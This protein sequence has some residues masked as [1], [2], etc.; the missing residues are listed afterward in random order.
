MHLSSRGFTLLELLAAMG[1]LV[2]IVLMMARIFADTTRMWNLGTKRI[3]ETQEARVVIDFLAR[4]I[5]MAIADELVSFKIH[6]ETSTSNMSVRAYGDD[7]DSICFVTTPR[8]PPSISRRSGNQHIYY[9]DYMRDP[10]NAT[11]VINEGHPEG[12]RYQLLRRTLTEAM[13]SFAGRTVSNDDPELDL[14]SSLRNL[15]VMNTAYR[16]KDWWLPALMSFSP[17]QVVLDNVVAFEIWA[18][19]EHYPSDMGY[20]FDST[21]VPNPPVRDEDGNP[22]PLGAPLWIDLYLEVIGEQESAKLGELWRQN[23]PDFAAF[24]EENV[25]RYSTRIYFRNREKMAE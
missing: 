10:T 17:G 24:R 2:I 15:G 16:R 22:R 9:V 18:E 1:I 21:Y 23:H 5:G 20:N 6:S 8:T 3:A 25:R 11:V 14:P 13:V 7:T 12:P 19:P 4:E